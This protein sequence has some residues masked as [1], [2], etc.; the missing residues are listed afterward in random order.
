MIVLQSSIYIKYSVSCDL[1]AAPAPVR[2]A[3]AGTDRH[4]TGPNLFGSG[5]V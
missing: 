2:P 5:P 4:R 1:S 3:Q